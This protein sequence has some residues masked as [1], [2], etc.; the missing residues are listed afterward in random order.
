MD[1]P[2]E[3]RLERLDAGH[4]A[5]QRIIDPEQR[6][7]PR[8]SEHERRGGRRLLR[9]RRPSG[10]TPAGSST[11][12]AST[13]SRW[14]INFGANFFGREGYP[15]SYYVRACAAARHRRDP[16]PQPDRQHRHVPPRQRLRARPAARE[17][18]QHRPRRALRDGGALQR[19]E[20]QH[21]PRAR[22][23]R[24]GTFDNRPGREH[25]HAERAFNDDPRDPEPADPPARRRA[26]R[27]D[28]SAIVLS[29][30]RPGIPGRAFSFS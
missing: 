2:R 27:S 6:L 4:P 13:S 22:Q 10:S 18:V 23:P 24:S 26:S 5:G 1:V 25:V 16:V 8:G 3:R 7:G 20:Q 15:Q 19:D 29:E 28:V 14:D 17:D 30:A 12:R 21:R 11:S 9:A